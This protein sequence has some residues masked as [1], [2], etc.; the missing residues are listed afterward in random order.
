M[1][2]CFPKIFQAKRKLRDGSQRTL[3]C[4]I[5]EA[6]Q[7]SLPFSLFLSS[8]DRSS[9]FSLRA[10]SIGHRLEKV[11]SVSDPLER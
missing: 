5:E 10:I 6:G 2:E 11:E 9:A 1:D 4:P 3:I 8:L 7:S